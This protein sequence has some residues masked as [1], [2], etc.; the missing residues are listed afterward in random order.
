[1]VESARRLG[2][3]VYCANLP[4]LRVCQRQSKDSVELRV[5]KL[6]VFFWVFDHSWGLFYSNVL[7]A[8]VSM[9]QTN[10]GKSTKFFFTPTFIFCSPICC[11]NCGVV[12]L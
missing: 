8:N 10:S 12:F 2:V 1:M 4:Q 7:R 5:F 9:H 6:T 11:N 3:R